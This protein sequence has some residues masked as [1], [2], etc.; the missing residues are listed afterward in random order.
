[1]VAAEKFAH[2]TAAVARAHEP[3]FVV[4][5]GVRIIE[6]FFTV[7]TD[8]AHANVYPDR[9]CFAVWPFGT[10]ALTWRCSEGTGNLDPIEFETAL[11][12]M[13]VQVCNPRARAIAHRHAS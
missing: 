7:D 3:R 9:R 6:V 10:H 12:R 8:G 4:D 1:M 2:F 5:S 13:R 11:E